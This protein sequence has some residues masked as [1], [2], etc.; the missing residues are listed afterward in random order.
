M[1]TTVFALL[2]LVALAQAPSSSLQVVSRFSLLSRTQPQPGYVYSQSEGLVLLNGDR[3]LYYGRTFDIGKPITSQSG[4]HLFDTERGATVQVFAPLDAF[5]RDHPQEPVRTFN[6][7][8]CYDRGYGRGGIL[9]ADQQFAPRRFYYLDW[10]LEVNRIE[11]AILL[12]KE[13]EVGKLEIYFR[14]IGS[15]AEK[16]ECYVAV[17]RPEVTEI[18]RGAPWKSHETITVLGIGEKVREVASFRT[19]RPKKGYYDVQRNRSAFIEYGEDKQDRQRGFVVD[20]GSGRVLGPFPV[21]KV[22]YGFAFD[23]D[24]KTV[25]AYS[26]N[27]GELW[28]IDLETLEVVRKAKHG[29]LGQALG[30]FDPDT[31]VLIHNGGIDFITRKTLKKRETIAMNQVDPRIRLI[32]GSIVLPGRLILRA[33]LQSV[34]VSSLPPDPSR[35]RSGKWLPY[36]LIHLRPKN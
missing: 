17:H 27:R 36:D 21:P 16:R 12:G 26:N 24:G 34:P 9:A 13:T 33:A 5:V 32:E 29:K 28:A 3:T 20:H 7:L 11:R 35:P 1:P 2:V 6:K 22:A 31:L 15:S 8:L 14:P 4:I 19:W 25:Y 18:P 23:P 30:L 10:D